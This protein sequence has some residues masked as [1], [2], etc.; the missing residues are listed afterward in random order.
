MTPAAPGS[1]GCG[2]ALSGR[3]RSGWPRGVM[4]GS[5]QESLGNTAS[6]RLSLRGACVVCGLLRGV[7]FGAQLSQPSVRA[8][9]T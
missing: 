4:V 9:K 7:L 2:A 6:S 5:P 8:I 1:L 3:G